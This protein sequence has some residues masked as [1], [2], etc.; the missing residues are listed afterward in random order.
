[1]NLSLAALATSALL[2]GV[3][4][5]GPEEGLEA[6]RREYRPILLVYLA[7]EEAAGAAPETV[8]GEEAS[9]KGGA[10]RRFAEEWT[11]SRKDPSVEKVLAGFVC[12]EVSRK[13]LEEPYPEGKRQQ[14]WPERSKKPRLLGERLGLVDGVPALLVLDF[15]EQV[16][17]R[18]QEKLPRRSALRKELSGLARRMARLAAAARR[19]EKILEAAEYSYALGETREAVLQVLP[20]DDP[21]AQKELD[22]VLADRVLWVLGRYKKDAGRA[23]AT[24]EAL[25]LEKRYMEAIQVYRQTA[26]RFPF[27]Q[28]IKLAIRRQ[29]EALRKEHTGL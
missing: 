13:A 17:W 29:E 27:P 7:A 6:A 20:L 10:R 24:G 12:V 26:Q 25:E 21:R 2:W 18:H 15:R 4:W 22:N 19:V 14:G 23:I 5:L 28:T 1:M 11:A 3:R 8:T 9:E 16:V